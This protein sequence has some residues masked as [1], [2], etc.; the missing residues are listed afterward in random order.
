M[1]KWNLDDKLDD[2]C[3][4]KY[5]KMVLKLKVDFVFVEYMFYYL[6]NEGMMVVVLLYGVLFCGVVEGKIW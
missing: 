6:N 5:G 3:F 4:W 2:E 1:V